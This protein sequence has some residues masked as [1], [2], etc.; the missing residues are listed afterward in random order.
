[1]E[2]GLDIVAADDSPVVRKAVELYLAKADCRVRTVEDGRAALC[3]VREARPD[4]LL[5]DII[6]PVMDGYEACAAVRGDAALRDLPV[7]FI[8]AL[9]EESDKA[10]AFALGAIDYIT[11]P[12]A[13][14]TL[15]FKI[16]SALEKN[17]R[18]QQPYK[19]LRARPEWSF[20]GFKRFIIDRLAGAP[21]T[22]RPALVNAAHDLKALAGASGMAQADMIRSAAQ[23]LGLGYAEL[24]DPETLELGALPPAFMRNNSAAIAAAGGRRAAF[25]SDP[26]DPQLTD[27]LRAMLGEDHELILCEPRAIT[28]LIDPDYAGVIFYDGSGQQLKIANHG[29]RYIASRLLEIF[30][31]ADADEAA[32]LPSGDG[33]AL[34]LRTGA[35]WRELA[36]LGKPGADLAA[37]GLRALAGVT[38]REEAPLEGAFSVVIGGGSFSFNFSLASGPAGERA[39]LTLR[40][41]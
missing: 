34:R 41:A 1:M 15:W 26:F 20:S 32:L 35:Q 3:A 13:P 8:S 25:I 11:K 10:R 17:R 29:A 18:W 40:R 24:I 2:R 38:G 4:V 36:Q 22:A 7:L 23:Y 12:F 39:A 21:G 19:I 31:A 30:A 16:S 28:G 14:E 5:L 9:A 37:S 6:M 33:A 27:T